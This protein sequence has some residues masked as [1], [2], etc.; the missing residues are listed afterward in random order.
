MA[1]LAREREISIMRLVGATDA[2]VRAPFL[3][4]GFVKGVLGGAL[5]LLLTWLAAA[6][7]SRYFIQ[8]AF[9]DAG[10]ATLG[11][12]IGAL[13]GLAGSALSVGRHLRRV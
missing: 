13:L 4:E 2:F 1:V 6:L 3:I 10:I 7:I 5:A 8:A 11:V 9:F 12:L